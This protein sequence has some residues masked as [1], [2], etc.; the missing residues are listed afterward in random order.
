[1][2]LKFRSVVTQNDNELVTEYESPYSE[3]TR[4]EFIVFNFLDPQKVE[5]E[6]AVSSQQV[7]IKSADNFTW[8]LYMHKYSKHWYKTDHGDIPLYWY[9]TGVIINTEIV[10]FTYDLLDNIGEKK[11][12]IGSV[13]VSLETK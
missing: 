1:M 2:N 4:D 9:L 6:I 8:D 5:Q 11:N 7:Q 3:T 13:K 10:S 12:I